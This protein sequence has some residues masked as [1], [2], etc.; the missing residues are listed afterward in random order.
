[1]PLSRAEEADEALLMGLRLARRHRPRPP[2]RIGGLQPRAPLSELTDAG[3]IE[4]CG[5]DRL[6]ATR[7]GRV[8]LNEVVLRLASALEPASPSVQPDPPAT[9][10]SWNKT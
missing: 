6:R 8:V 7:S 5:S 3:L 2:G 10:I 4:R 9:Q 1:M